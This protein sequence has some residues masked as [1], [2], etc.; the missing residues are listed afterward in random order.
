MPMADSE[1]PAASSP[2]FAPRGQPV[3]Q[4][5]H[6]LTAGHAV[7]HNAADDPQHGRRSGVDT[8][9]HAIS[10]RTDLQAEDEVDRQDRGDHLRGDVG[11]QADRAECDDVAAD[12]G[13]ARSARPRRAVGPADAAAVHGLAPPAVE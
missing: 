3:A 8:I 7:G 5:G 10:E 9:D 11:D 13:R 2:S 1:R 6:E 12:E 4:T